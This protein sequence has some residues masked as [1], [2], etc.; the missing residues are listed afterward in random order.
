MTVLSALVPTGI[1]PS[2]ASVLDSRLLGFALV[3]AIG[4]GLLFSIVPAAQAARTSLNQALQE[5]GRTR[6]GS[7]TAIRDALVVAQVALA[8][9][10]LVAAGLLVRTLGNLRSIDLGFRVENLLTMRTTL[11][12]PKYQDP[13]SRLAFYERVV[14]GVRALPGVEHAAFV[15]TL[16][17]L[18]AGNTSGYITE[19]GI[20]TPGQDSLFRVGTAD[21]LNTIGVKLLEGRLLV[22]SDNRDAPMVVV[23]NETLARLH[24]PGQ[25]A[26]SRRVRFG[27]ND[28]WR[29]IV[30][31]VR[32]VRERGYEREMKP[33][34]YVPYSQQLTSWFPESLIIRTAGD[35]AAI[36]QAARRIVASVDPDQPVAAVQ[37]MK[38]IV[39]RNV[40]DRTDQT[41]L[42]GAFAALALLLAAI[43]LYGV[44]SYSV[45]Q[46]SREIGLRMALG[47]SAGSVTRLVMTRGLAL[48][49]I[50]LAIGLALSWAVG[51]TLTTLLYGVEAADPATFAGTIALL[52]LVALVACGLP[53]WRAARVDP[54]NVLR[55]D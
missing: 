46:R 37:T 4:T 6:I 12:N 33:G 25:S 13:T 28:P 23:V 36:A 43:G 51:R 45:T 21:Y 9:A 53:A 11:P 2:S 32:D 24:W 34:T 14:A 44:L 5:G 40:A 47:A 17:F 41:T 7:R 38:E 52:T 50:G 35:P 10:L 22:E 39:D 31:V 55:Q 49:A 42:V 29:T 48:T 18:S 19:G 26:L 27:S 30:G 16:P 8:L 3:L 20:D 15:S 1:V 54:M